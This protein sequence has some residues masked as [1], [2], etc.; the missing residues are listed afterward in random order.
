MTDVQLA[1]VALFGG[2]GCAA[3]LWLLRKAGVL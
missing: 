1:L 2:L 3:A